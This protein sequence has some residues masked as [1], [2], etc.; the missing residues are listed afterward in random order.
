MERLGPLRC[1]PTNPSAPP[2]TPADVHVPIGTLST[3]TEHFG[4]GTSIGVTQV[5]GADNSVWSA[6]S[7]G[8]PAQRQGLAG[9]RVLAKVPAMSV[10]SPGVNGPGLA[11]I[12]ASFFPQV[13]QAPLSRKGFG[14]NFHSASTKHRAA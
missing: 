3:D 14:K 7:G 11:I 10:T 6:R 2:G 8:S 1:R 4:P 9:G 13:T 12:S 5:D